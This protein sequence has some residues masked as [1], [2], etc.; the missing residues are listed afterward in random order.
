[1][2]YDNVMDLIGH[3][4]I[5]TLDRFF[6]H[7]RVRV[8]AKL[9]G[10][11]PSG[12]I[13][14][15]IALALLRDARDRGSISPGDTIIEPTDGNIGV[16]LAMLAGPMEYSFIAVTPEDTPSAQVAAM[17]QFGARVIHTAAGDGMPASWKHAEELV[18]SKG[19]KTLSHF[20]RAVASETHQRTTAREILLSLGVHLNYFIAGVG[21]GA[22]FTGV[23]SVLREH[24]PDVKLLAV[25]PAASPVLSGG[26]PGRHAIRGIGCGCVP[27]LL[28]RS[29]I[30]RIV[31]VG[32]GEAASAARKLAQREGLRA[33]P[34]SGAVLAATGKL[35]EELPAR[36][37][38][39]SVILIILPDAG[40]R[41]IDL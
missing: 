10:F 12:S 2:S 13:K 37:C 39:R 14:D 21:S 38:R 27:Q 32:D 3:T 9:E 40:H 7:G 19:H 6:P 4:P 26:E 25:E 23:A 20:T 24:I 11:N 41:Y 31:T 22:T 35:V 5:V 28:D 29:L 34:S 8:Y 18:R 33:G 16:S 1:M 17:R 15:R 36:P 30:D